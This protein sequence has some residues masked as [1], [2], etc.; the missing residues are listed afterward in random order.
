MEYN[1]LRANSIRSNSVGDLASVA[2]AQTGRPS[3]A[4]ACHLLP[5]ER[6]VVRLRVAELL[7][8]RG[9]KPYDLITGAGFSP[10]ASYKLASE[11]GRFERIGADTID[12][13]CAFFDVTPGE[14]FVRDAQSGTRRRTTRPRSG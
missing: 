6:R 2:P 4:M 9:L 1:S 7:R 10:H 11:N 8:Q 3:C 5:R 13:L 14:L 12:R